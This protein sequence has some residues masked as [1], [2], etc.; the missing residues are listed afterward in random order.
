MIDDPKVLKVFNTLTEIAIATPKVSN[1]RLAAAISVK[2]RIVSFGANSMKSSPFQKRY[3][4]N[5]HHIFYH[6]EI[7]AIKNSLRHLEVHE[8]RK[9]T[10]YVCRI[11]TDHGKNLI[12]ANAKPCVGCFRAIVEFEIPRVLYT[13]EDGIESL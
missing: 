2:N 13:T 1:T 11:K 8:L 4:K 6:A 3:A 12:W 9:A 7:A 5:E 10:L